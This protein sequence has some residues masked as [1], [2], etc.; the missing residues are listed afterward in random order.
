MY[1][2]AIAEYYEGTVVVQQAIQMAMVTDAS[3]AMSEDNRDISADMLEKVS[4]SIKNL[5]LPVTKL[6]I[7]DLQEIL[8][9]FKKPFTYFECGQLLVNLSQTMRRELQAFKVFALD[10]RQNEMYF[11]KEPIFGAEVHAKFPSIILDANEAAKCIALTRPTAAVF[12]S[13]HVIEHALRAVHLCLSLPIPDNPSWG[14][15]LSEIRKERIKRG[16]KA[17]KE[18]LFFQDIWQH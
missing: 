10:P 13:M 2:I 1:E 15:W 6:T 11:P 7:S 17:W 12:H 3:H 4:V 9:K 16:D 18:N 5:P 14:I 8:R